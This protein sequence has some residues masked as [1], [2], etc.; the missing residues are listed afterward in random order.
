MASYFPTGNQLLDGLKPFC[1][2]RKIEG[3][4]CSVG[5]AATLTAEALSKAGYSAKDT[6]AKI[7]K[8]GYEGQL[9]YERAGLGEITAPLL[10]LFTINGGPEYLVKYGLATKADVA[11]F[12]KL[13]NKNNQQEYLRSQGVHKK[14]AVDK[15]CVQKMIPHFRKQAGSQGAYMA[16][17][18]FAVQAENWCLKNG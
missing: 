5:Y 16:D 13:Y 9:E 10:S 12:A 17:D 6:I 18:I 4:L 15:S 3:D 11:T 1:N 2:D 14:K 7:G 8:A